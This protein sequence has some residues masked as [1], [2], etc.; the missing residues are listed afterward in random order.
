[1]QRTQRTVSLSTPLPGTAACKVETDDR[2]VV[3]ARSERINGRIEMR[4]I[5]TGGLVIVL[6]GLLLAV[7]AGPAF[8]QGADDCNDAEVIAGDGTFNFDSSGATTDGVTNCDNSTFGADVWFAWTANVTGT[9]TLDTCGQAD[10]DTMVGVY[11]L[12]PCPPSPHLACNDDDC[13]DVL[14]R[15]S[16]PAV[17]GVTYLVRIGGFAGDTGSGTFTIAT[18]PFFGGCCLP[19]GSCIDQFLEDCD[20]NGGVFQ[21]N[22][23]TC[24]GPCLLKASGFT[25]QGRLDL[26]GAP[27]NDTADFDFTLWDAGTNGTIIGSVD[28]VHGVTVVN[29]LFTVVLNSGDQ[30]GPNAFDG[31]PR[32]LKIDVRSPGGSGDF[33]TLSPRQAITATPSATHS[34]NTRGIFVADLGNVGI[35]T[36]TPSAALD[37]VGTTE[38]NGEVTIGDGVTV[39]DVIISNGGLCVDNDGNCGSPGAGGIR[40]GPA[41]I[42]GTNSSNNNLLLVPDGDGNVG[43]GTT[44]P[45]GRLHVTNNTA[46][47][48]IRF[49][50]AGDNAIGRNVS[51]RFRH[52]NGEGAK[53]NAKREAGDDDGMNLTFS[54]QPIG[55][56]VTERMVIDP[57]GNVGI[58]TASPSARLDVVGTTELNGDVTINSN[59]TVDT[60]TLFVDGSSGRVGIGQSSPSAKLDVVGTTELNGDVLVTSTG[61]A[62]ISVERSGGAT[63]RLEAGSGAARIEVSDHPLRFLINRDEKLR[64]DT[65]G[66]VG[67][68]TSN[69][70]AKLDVVGTTELNGNVTINSSKL[71]VYDFR[72][73][74]DI[75]DHV[76]LIENAR[77]TPGRHVLALKM[78][79][80]SPGSNNNFVTFFNS[81]DVGLGAIEGDNAGG[82]IYKSGAAD[83]AEY[84]P[85][86]NHDER[87][88]PGDVV[89]VFGGRIAKQ[90]DGAD[91]VM[92]VS[93]TPITLGNMQKSQE[94]EALHETVAFI[95]QVPVKVRGPVAV[96]DYVT[97]SG[98]EDG[99]A[100]AI[101][102]HQIDPANGH[103]I[104]GRAWEASDDPEVKLINTVVGLPESSST[105]AALARTVQS[106]QAQM[107]DQQAQIADLSARLDALAAELVKK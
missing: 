41:G 99:T 37:V 88:E 48:S 75:G 66:K 107:D 77:D 53:I 1:M 79:A 80:A 19:D 29:G 103:L 3:D 95:G 36:T 46:D 87:I 47:P 71:T 30:F 22:G 63:I 39:A 84:M 21:G 38:F 69:P 74:S 65:S 24:T 50:N 34:R 90:T 78:N 49:E 43:I 82:V 73:G 105:T 27:L 44:S 12:L 4:T 8:G 9:P 15:M 67:I 33:T 52:S 13:D 28:E 31:S 96:G 55:G 91:W 89:G 58:G 35:G 20:A 40:V 25:Y 81:N 45:T 76:A 11:D 51:I 102:F 5:P 92:A 61:I 23:S 72:T 70:S 60:D 6:A 98:M 32:W 17:A 93:T 57:D 56:S 62:R 26:L 86:L 97:A 7:E 68:G 59:L 94:L 104:V 100:V 2:A 16:W 54:T 64:I 106:Q 85:R 18:T 42:H 10:F 83:F 14:S 101:P